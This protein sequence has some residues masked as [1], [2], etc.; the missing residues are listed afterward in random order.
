[1]KSEWKRVN[2]WGF[3]VQLTD[4]MFVH[5]DIIDVENRRSKKI[6]K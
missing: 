6:E 1:M 4:V 3:R 5:L 2:L